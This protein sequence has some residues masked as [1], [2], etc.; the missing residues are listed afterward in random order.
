MTPLPIKVVI[1]TM[2]EPPPGDTVFTEGELR[3]WVEGVPLPERVPFPF[4]GGDLR[5]DAERGV[6]ALLT[7]VG[8]AAA[9]AAVTA[10]G[11]HPAFDLS[12]AYWIMAGIGGADP[13]EMPIGSAC[14]IDW[15][16]DGDLMHEVD[17]LDAPDHW[18]TGRLPLGK[19]EPFAQPA[20]ARVATPA[21]RLDPGLV[22]WAHRLTA[23]MPLVDSEEMARFRAHFDGTA[24]GAAAPVVT[25]GA[26]LGG[27]DFWH[28]PR[29]LDWARGWVPYWTGGAARF[30]VSAME[31]AGIALALHA[32][33]R[34]GRADA[35]RLLMLRT[36]SNYVVP[37]PGLTAAQGLG[38]HKHEALCALRPS[39]ENAFRV[40]HRV[41]EALLADWGRHEQA[42]P[43]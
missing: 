33:A 3:R 22:G 34:A 36:A 14:W 1:L 27:S 15:V 5:L 13:E 28:G 26:V 35:R 39:L 2:F 24:R 38:S 30:V 6:L 9:A 41:V 37:R 40:G 8:N 18:S 17:R 21:W 16:V 25:T 10:L 23:D 19:A 20:M 32:L 43:G 29:M 7:G 11:L 42:P 31:D 4:G 12:R